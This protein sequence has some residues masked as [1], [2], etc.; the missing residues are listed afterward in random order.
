MEERNAET[1]RQP[2]RQKLL[3]LI[4]T[5]AV[6]VADQ[7]TKALVVAHIPQLTLFS[8]DGVIRVLGDYVR[9]IHVRNKAVAFSMGAGLPA[10]IRLVLFSLMPLAIIVLVFVVYFRNDEFLPLQRWAICG[11]LGGGI[12]NL[13]DRFFRPDGV[14]DFIDCY[15][16]GLFGMERWPTFNVA[17][18]AVV[19]CI[20]LFALSFIA[21]TRRAE[22]S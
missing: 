22:K 21:Q 3:P 20:V 6:I 1:S 15:F 14:V 2:L 18:S 12:G 5:L 9:L 11:I 8:D 7:V 10:D 4:L 19:V 16:F 13:I 17:D